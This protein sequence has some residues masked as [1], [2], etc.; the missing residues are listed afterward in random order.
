MASS[1]CSCMRLNARGAPPPSGLSEPVQTGPL[2]SE[3]LHQDNWEI[4][5]LPLPLP[6][7]LP[8]DLAHVNT[9]A[10]LQT[11]LQAQLERPLLGQWRPLLCCL[12][13][14]WTMRPHACS[15]SSGTP[16]KR[17]N[18]TLCTRRPSVL[19]AAA[20]LC[21]GPHLCPYVCCCETTHW[22]HWPHPLSQQGFSVR[23]LAAHS[24]YKAS[25]W[26]SE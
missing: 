17:Y 23:R 25:T 26:V 13:P 7:Q 1:P 16:T 3:P 15:G 18:S 11:S 6:L 20:H 21:P 12:P 9:Q 10:S 2:Q 4:S 14:V 22:R 5:S 19:C 24:L 8:H